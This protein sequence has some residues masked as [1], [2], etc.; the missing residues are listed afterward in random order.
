MFQA[1][2]PTTTTS[3]VIFTSKQTGRVTSIKQCIFLPNFGGTGCG[4]VMHHSTGTDT[5]T[6]IFDHNTCFI[7]GGVSSGGYVGQGSSS[8][9]LKLPADFITSFRSNIFWR[10]T[11]GPGMILFRVAARN[12]LTVALGGNVGSNTK[13]NVSSNATPNARTEG[14]G[15]GSDVDAPLF[16]G[17]LD[18][19]T[20]DDTLN[21]SFADR[22]HDIRTYAR[23]IG[24]YTGTDAEVCDAL[25]NAFLAGSNTA[26]PNYN[27][28]VSIS[29]LLTHIE[30]GF[31]PTSSAVQTAHDSEVGG[32][33]GAV[34]GVA[35]GSAAF[36]SYYYG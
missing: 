10:E 25:T 33:R 34:E 20:T 14:L 6:V 8:D 24:G 9:A 1:L 5:G 12:N 32:W 15:Y 11:D 19:L 35:G 23:E 21:P 36:R 27:A 22:T 26:H 31:T 28:A 16:N 2:S 18:G 30:Q 13:W 17:T 7:S 29:G 3:D 4:A